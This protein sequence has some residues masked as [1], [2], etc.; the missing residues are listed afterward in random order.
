[1]RYSIFQYQRRLAARVSEL[2][3]VRRQV[4]ELWDR[5]EVSHEERARVNDGVTNNSKASLE[6]VSNCIGN[7][8]IGTNLNSIK[9]ADCPNGAVLRQQRHPVLA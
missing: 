2:A 8:T 4:E 6:T 7:D 1:M 3:G 5:L 9:C